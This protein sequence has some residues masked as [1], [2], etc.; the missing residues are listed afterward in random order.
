MSVCFGKLFLCFSAAVFSF[1]WLH[2]ILGHFFPSVKKKKKKRKKQR[3]QTKCLVTHQVPHWSYKSIL[4]A[5]HLSSWAISIVDRKN[6]I[7]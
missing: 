5:V 6:E 2:F 3:N 7:K 4:S 1:Y